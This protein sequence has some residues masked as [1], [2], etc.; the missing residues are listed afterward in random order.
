MRKVLAV[1]AALTLAGCTSES[2][3]MQF[4]PHPTLVQNLADQAK[5][6]TEAVAKAAEEEQANR[7]GVTV[8]RLREAKSQLP[9]QQR[10]KVAT[11]MMVG[12]RDYD[13]AK[14]ALEQGAGGIF[15]GSWTSPAL[16]TEPGRDLKALRAEIGRPF[17]VSIDAE[18]GRVQ[19]QPA[20]FGAVP[21]P[22]SIA[23]SKTPAQARA[24]GFELG[25]GL[26][27]AGVTV[28]FAPVLDVDGGKA[29]GA[30]GDRSFSSDPDTA[31]RYGAAFAQGLR[32]AGIQPVYK[33]FP[34]HGRVSGD[35]HFEDVTSPSLE[36]VKSV[37]LA[38]Y[39]PALREAPG[40]VMV[41]HVRVPGLGDASPSTINPAAYALLR[42]GD[43]PGGA[44][45][46][47]V[48]YTDDLS[49]MKAISNR[50]STPQAATAAL[51]AGADCALWISTGA[52]SE[53]I[54]STDNAVSAGTYPQAQL[55]DSALRVKLQ[56]LDQQGFR[57]AG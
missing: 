18:G 34:G 17:S 2:E 25:R 56:Q 26:R 13:D 11:L 36:S 10:A 38:P 28:D 55:E 5:Q 3:S 51:V 6:E 44:P 31:A 32:D 23:E 27:T 54:D 20:L 33:H 24:I 35:S 43:Y 57:P 48:V 22:R 9:T 21:A 15:I 52:L 53:A 16:L 37:D 19:R 14:F 46:R 39:G 12:V 49:G 4:G 47:G 7:L 42:S 50:L 1:L 41:G 45:H 40:A 8:D 30:I 29:G